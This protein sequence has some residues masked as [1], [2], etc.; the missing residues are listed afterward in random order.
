[1]GERKSGF[2]FLKLAIVLVVLSAYT[3]GITFLSFFRYLLLISIPLLVSAVIV[4]LVQRSKCN[5]DETI[6]RIEDSRYDAEFAVTVSEWLNTE[7]TAL[8]RKYYISDYTR[9]VT[10]K[11]AHSWNIY[12]FGIRNYMLI[13]DNS[14]CFLPIHSEYTAWDGDWARGRR[15]HGDALKAELKHFFTCIQIPISKIEHFYITGEY[16]RESKISGGGG[17]G[18]SL[19]GA[20]IGGAIAG[21]AGAVIGSRKKVSEIKSELVTHDTR[22]TIL[23]YFSNNGSRETIVL[24]HADYQVLEDLIPEKNYAVVTEARRQLLVQKS[25]MNTGAKAITEQIKELATL[26][27]N[28]ILTE[29]EFATKKKELLAKI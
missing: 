5:K 15:Y 20:I 9:T 25:I 27:D 16:F 13:Y 19:G 28:G 26:K 23:S 3:Y 12:L 18:S 7:Y 29:N 24:H 11:K 8:W 21:G 22:E 2:V 10:M 6:Q 1:M 4:V 14:L 17:G